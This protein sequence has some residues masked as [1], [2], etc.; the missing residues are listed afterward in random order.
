M[1]FRLLMMQQSGIMENIINKYIPEKPRCAFDSKKTS[2][3]TKVINLKQ[4]WGAF[5]ILAIGLLIGFTAFLAEKISH[6]LWNPK[7]ETNIELMVSPTS[8]T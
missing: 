2:G 8:Q 1:Q 5:I 3:N 7:R 4:V 6:R